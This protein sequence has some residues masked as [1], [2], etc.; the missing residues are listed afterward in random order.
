MTEPFVEPS[1][2]RLYDRKDKIPAWPFVVGAVLVVG[3]GAML[4]ANQAYRPPYLDRT[5]MQSLQVSAG[6]I[7]LRVIP[8]AL[9][10]FAALYFGITRTLVP[11]QAP[12]QALLIVMAALA[13]VATIVIQAQI[14]KTTYEREGRPA[15]QELLQRTADRY[16]NEVL[17]S[18]RAL[19]NRLSDVT[20]P[21]FFFWTSYRREREPDY[22][23]LRELLA[24]ARDTVGHHHTYIAQQQ[25]QAVERIRQSRISRFGKAEA[26]Q[27]LEARFSASDALR[28]R[29][30]EL[31]RQML[32]ELEGEVDILQRANAAARA[33]GFQGVS[34]GDQANRMAF[35]AHEERLAQITLELDD[36]T[37][38]LVAEG[39]RVRA[40]AI[41]RA[42]ARRQARL[43]A[44]TTEP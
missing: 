34:F 39:R 8:L 30:F 35:Q 38:D 11:R 4:L 28:E 22:D 32:T 23:Y 2:G 25:A 17:M 13:G 10:A 26:I 29:H 20:L 3:F 42:V 9:I 12:L 7:A 5:T 18:H 31:A 36:V 41:D 37:R 21:G 33:D 43:D 6:P 19:N 14:E 1:L 27:A 40:D 44:E 15:T 16:E 24:D